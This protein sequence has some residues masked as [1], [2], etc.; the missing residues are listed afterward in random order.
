MENSYCGLRCTQ[1]TYKTAGKCAGCKPG[2]EYKYQEDLCRALEIAK[3]RDQAYEAGLDPSESLPLL[4]DSSFKNIKNFPEDETEESGTRYSTYCPIAI[5]CKNQK[6][7]S[8][9]FCDKRF[10]CQNYNSKV[11]MNSVIESKLNLWGVTTHG[12]KESVN[13]QR[14]LLICYILLIIPSVLTKLASSPAIAL[15][16]I[17]LSGVAMYG[18]SKMIPYSEI[19][20][21]T[22]LFTIGDL[23]VRFLV[24]IIDYGV[25]VNGA[26]SIF[27][28]VI[29]VINYKITFDAYADMV[30]DVDDRLEKRWLRVWPFTIIIYIVFA[31]LALALQ[32]FELILVPMVVLN[33]III[34]NMLST[35]SVCKNN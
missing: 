23:L 22:I 4:E 12:L 5:C 35:I 33:I 9:F 29:S 19:F 27:G 20:R 10:A 8:C 17:P 24:D 14:L 16:Y 21:V 34:L 13:Y 6:I 32:S 28:A 18:Y 26:L 1:C 2:I 31:V 25:L 7:E 11:N 15:I 30:S 3:K